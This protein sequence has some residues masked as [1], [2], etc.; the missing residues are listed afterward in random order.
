ME[1]ERTAKL[2]IVLGFNGTGKTTL[3]KKIVLNEAQKGKRSL[4]I[5][6]DDMEWQTI[7]YVHHKHTHHIETYTRAR[8]MVFYQPSITEAKKIGEKNTL[9]II[10]DHY[11]NGLLVFDDCRAYFDSLTPRLLHELLIRRRQ[12]MLD[13]IAIG[14]GFTE[15]P[16][17]FFTFASEIILFKTQDNIERRKNVIKDFEKMKAA[18]IQVNKMAETNPHAYK[19][20]K[21]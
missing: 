16:P 14:H 6:P 1:T 13:I 15:V 18:Q 19:I 17:T 21:Q 7:Q 10:K 12:K 9:E 2:I 3:V 11:S 4:V 8:K 20:I 5:I